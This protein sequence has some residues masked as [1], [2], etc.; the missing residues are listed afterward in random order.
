M[1]KSTFNLGRITALAALIGGAQYVSA[2]DNTMEEIVVTGSLIK[3]TPEDSTIPVDTISAEELDK[4]GAPPPLEM[5]KNLSYMNGIVGESNQFTGGRGQAAQGTAS[6]NLRGLGA[7]R[8]LVLLNGKRLSSGD[9]N[10]LPT[11]AIARVEVLKDGGAVTYGSDAIG[12]VVNYITKEGVEGFEASVDYRSIPD[13]DGD[14]NI[15]LTWGMVSDNS[16]FFTSLNYYH[17]SELAIIDRDWGIQPYTTNPEGGWGSGANP[18]SFRGTSF[19]AFVGNNF[20]DPACEDVGGVL[21]T[22]A[23]PDPNGSTCRTQY[24][25]WDNFVEEQDS[26]QWFAGYNLDL[27]ESTRLHVEALYA[28]TD[29]PHANTTPGYTT[30]NSVPSGSALNPYYLIPVSNPGL[31]DLVAQGVYN[32]FGFLPALGILNNW[33]PFF[34]GGNPLF[35]YEE[36][37]TAYE[38]DQFRLSTE[39]T[40]DLTDTLSYRTSLTYSS[41]ES[42]RKEWDMRIDRL[43]AALNG[44]GGFD[45][46]NVTAGANGCEYFNPFS[47]AYPSNPV[48]GLENPYYDETLANS[49]ELVDWL[50]DQHASTT[51]GENV[52]FNFLLTGD[53]GVELAGGAVDWAAGMQYRHE[54]D[55]ADYSDFNNQLV[56][57]CPVYGDT[58][59]PPEQ[60]GASPWIFLATY[61]PYEYDR[62]VKA[63]FGEMQL[64]ITDAVNLQLA[65]RYE[66]Y[67]NIGGDSFDPSLRLRIQATDWMAFRFSA[68]TTFRGVPQTTLSPNGAT[69]FQFV[70]GNSTPVVTTG[71][72]DLVPE[73]STNYNV[74]VMFAGENFDLNIDY[75]RFDLDKVITAEPISGIVA[76]V[77]VCDPAFLSYVELSGPCGDVNTNITK[78]TRSS[79]NGAGRMNDGIDIQGSYTWDDVASGALSLGLSAT[80][81]LHFE[82]EDLIVDGVV[83]EQGF[84]GVGQFNAQTTLFPL[85]AWRGNVFLNYAFGSQNIRWSA[86]FV[87]SYEDQ[88]ASVDFTNFP[89]GQKIDSIVTHNV[90]YRWDVNDSLTLTGVIDNLTDEDPP[91]AR[92]EINYDAV[93]HTPL[94]RT[95]KVGAKYRF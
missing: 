48:L 28:Y 93:T 12:G 4:Q 82:T 3:G 90:T 92:T 2:Q 91:F 51:K 76:G 89:E 43:V 24:T 73:E 78:V 81:I 13:S 94:G 10:R 88:R 77:A 55:E 84:D 52:E 80:R 47:S 74:G 68:G 33:R 15:G 29:V 6:I 37:Y 20:V 56:N 40:G 23:L 61:T 86:Q 11:N 53:L 25:I 26:Y 42:E 67:G 70:N 50:M 39:L 83:F 5:L 31:Q 34:S 63:V 17:R 71:N 44:F 9:A 36:A 7:T 35:G 30:A 72:P 8:T 41:A 59:C 38:R 1:Y 85:P 60:R 16:D 45:C 18:G 21:T 58:S 64:P 57:P 87:D 62:E 75:W 27:T 49:P 14:Y 79:I 65:A 66:D 32:N 22:G 95:V 69:G 46:D 19:G 54:T